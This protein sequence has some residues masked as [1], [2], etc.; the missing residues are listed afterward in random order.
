VKCVNCGLYGHENSRSSQC[1]QS[2]YY[3][4][5]PPPSG[6]TLPK[7]T[8]LSNFHPRA[9]NAPRLMHTPYISQGP[10]EGNL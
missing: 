3:K 5:P 1:P 6:P 4:E 8:F 9:P 2:K 10:F 7:L